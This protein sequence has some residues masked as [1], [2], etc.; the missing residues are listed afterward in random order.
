MISYECQLINYLKAWDIEV[1]LLLNLGKTP[2][3]KRKVLT[4]DYKNHKVS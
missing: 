2:E 4:V 3:L 1:G